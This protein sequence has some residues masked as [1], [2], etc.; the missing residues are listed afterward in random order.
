[1]PTFRVVWEFAENT[2]STFNEVYYCD[3]TNA[4]SAA[5]TGNELATNRV[6]FLHPLNR[7]VQ[8]RSSQVDAQRVTGLATYNFFGTGG[9]A[10][11]P[12][13]PG[14]SIVCTLGGTTGGS[15]KIWLR[16]AADSAIVRDPTS[17][18]DKPPAS[19]ITRLEAWFKSLKANG[20]GLRQVQTQVPGPLQ[21]KK[22]T[23]VDGSTLDGVSTITLS[24]P[25][26]I[27]FPGR[28][29]IGGCSK[30]DLPGINGRWSI[31]G[32]VAGNTVKIPYQTPQGITVTGGN[33]KLRQESYQAINVFD[34]ASCNFAY[35]TTRATK[36]PL[37]HS[38]GARR[39]VRNRTSL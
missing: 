3:A 33:G 9:N 15:R 22:I 14:D 39:A 38:R 31:L 5:N 10:E 30:K 16:G 17:G 37:T 4:K 27:P 8:I 36:N 18:I 1:V 21:N 25:P 20:Y 32:P 29:I 26:G 6:S 35:Y 28:V 12:A 23:I 13:T 19:L 24:D 11:G 2:G 34:P 7:L